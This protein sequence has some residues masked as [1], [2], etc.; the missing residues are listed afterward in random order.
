MTFEQTASLLLETIVDR[1]ST[2]QYTEAIRVYTTYEMHPEDI[3]LDILRPSNKLDFFDAIAAT[4][5]FVVPQLLDAFGIS[6]T[7]VVETGCGCVCKALARGDLSRARYYVYRF[8]IGKLD[9]HVFPFGSNPFF[10]ACLSNNVECISW[11][12]DKITGRLNTNTD[13]AFYKKVVLHNRFNAKTLAWLERYLGI[14]VAG[15]L[16]A[17]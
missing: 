17:N 5:M 11:A 7:S 14:P 2:G 10:H 6:R 4:D 3:V 8:A 9:F 15:I 12:H 13:A 1:I 16:H